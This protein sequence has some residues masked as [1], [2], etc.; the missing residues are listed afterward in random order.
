M[1]RR[2]D[3]PVKVI[4]A[5]MGLVVTLGGVVVA[6]FGNPFASDPRDAAA[7]TTPAALA[8]YQINKC[9]RAHQMSAQSQIV[10]LRRPRRGT[11]FENT[12]RTQ[13]R[14]CD[15]PPSSPAHLDGYT[16]ITSDGGW[17]RGK[18]AADQ[19]AVFEQMLAP[20]DELVLTFVIGHMNAR[21]FGTIRLRQARL[22]GAFGSW[23]GRRNSVAP[24][25]MDH[26][27]VD[28]APRFDLDDRFNVLHGGHL[29]VYDVRC[30]AA[31]Q[32]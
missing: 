31:Q 6:T 11:R 3:P 19:Y 32:T 20:C 15:W 2:I 25:L 8:A 28:V 10:E 12:W 17:I 29:N 16:E 26:V 18:V 24:H 30:A 14:R 5:I 27:P 13:Y 21:T 22:A 23:D 9:M 1:W 7:F 4:V